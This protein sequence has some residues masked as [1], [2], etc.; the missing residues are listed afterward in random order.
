MIQDTSA[1]PPL[2]AK[3]CLFCGGSTEGKSRAREHILSQ[4]LL[5]EFSLARELIQHSQVRTV[6][7]DFSGGH[8]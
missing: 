5:R 2:S 8:V 1:P 6:D 4:D 3:E 7:G